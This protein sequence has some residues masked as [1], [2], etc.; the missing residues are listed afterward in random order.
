MKTAISPTTSVR[1]L[2]S[3]RKHLIQPESTVHRLEN[4]IYQSLAVEGYEVDRELL[5]KR[6]HEITKTLS[7]PKR[8]EKIH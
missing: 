8:L 4:S 7:E 5:R 1:A 6:T 2:R 3:E